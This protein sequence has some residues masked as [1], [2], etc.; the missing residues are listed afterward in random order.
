MLKLKYNVAIIGATGLVGKK[1]VQTLEHLRFPIGNL[2]L[3]ASQKNIGK[4]TLAFGKI[5]PLESLENNNLENIDVAFFATDKDVSLKYAPVFEKLG[6]I[7]VDNSSAFRQDK[8]VPLV[9]PEINPEKIFSSGRKIIANPNCSTIVALTP[10]KNVY[11]KYR[12][13]QLIFSTYQ[14]VS[15]NG[16]DGIA[17]LLRTRQ[18]FSPSFYPLNI[19]KT[20]LPQIGDIDENGESEEEKKMANETKK[21]LGA[22]VAVSATCVRVPTENCHGVAVEANFDH[23][24][25]LDEIKKEMIFDGVKHSDLPNFGEAD[26]NANIFFGRLRKSRV[27]D[28]G[29]SFFSVGDNLLKG[30]SLNAVQIAEI[31]VK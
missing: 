1:F 30:A 24:I 6:T 22:D 17:D 20:I 7:V 25:D 11:K 19:A 12:L 2:R 16:R 10:L 9:I 3:F 15:G 5:L 26:G 28:N 29:I 13:K 31:I 14:S 8:D 21:I 18:G 27:F 23:P 4:K